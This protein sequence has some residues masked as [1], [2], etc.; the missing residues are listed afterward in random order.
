MPLPP[1][2]LGWQESMMVNAGLE[3]GH[4]N[5]VHFVVNNL[6]DLAEVNRVDDRIVAVGFVIVEAIDLAAGLTE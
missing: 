5:T 3:G 4:H 1:S 6:A 2:L